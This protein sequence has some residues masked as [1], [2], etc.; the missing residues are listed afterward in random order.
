VYKERLVSDVTQSVSRG[1]SNSAHSSM[2]RPRHEIDTQVVHNSYSRRVSKQVRGVYCYVTLHKFA[3]TSVAKL[4]DASSHNGAGRWHT[5]QIS[6]ETGAPSADALSF[7]QPQF[8]R[9][10]C[11]Y[12]ETCCSL[13]SEPSVQRQPSC[14][15]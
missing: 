9:T 2:K 13:Q 7:N 1:T 5:T 15:V 10:N 12:M 6:T 3:F 14:A 11:C 4:V 8:R